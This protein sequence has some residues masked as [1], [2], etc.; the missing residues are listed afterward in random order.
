MACNSKVGCGKSEQINT[1]PG[2][3]TSFNIQ[4]S[5]KNTGEPIPMSG[6][7]SATAF[8]AQEISD[9]PLSVSGNLLSQDLAKIGFVITSTDSA[10]LRIGDNQDF[11]IEVDRGSETI[12]E[13]II[14]KLNVSKR[15]FP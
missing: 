10:S 14:G 5:D 15:L 1:T 3:T 6:F 12:I 4:L 7:I 11:E 8:F 13:Q 2:K 9:L